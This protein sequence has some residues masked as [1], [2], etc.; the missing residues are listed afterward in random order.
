MLYSRILALLILIAASVW[1]GSGVLGREEPAADAGKEIA[2]ATPPF[3]VAVIEAQVELHARSIVLSGRTEADDRASAVARTAGTLLELQVERGSAVK[4]GQ[5]IALLSDEARNAQVEQAEA[6]LTQRRTEL[7]ARL[8]LIERG[9]SPKIQKTQ[10]QVL[11]GGKIYISN[12]T[13]GRY[14]FYR[15]VQL[16]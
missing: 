16:L 14:C 2:T 13:A 10:I 9:V 6:R 1:I 11:G 12:Q 15:L 5:V 4:K 8:R 7:E 3:Q